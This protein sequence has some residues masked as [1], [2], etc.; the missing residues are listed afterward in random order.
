MFIADIVRALLAPKL[1]E[2]KAALDTGDYTNGAWLINQAC[3]EFPIF[4][5]TIR[6]LFNG[7]PQEALLRL[8]VYA[9][10]LEKLPN[11]VGVVGVLQAELRR[12]WEK[13]RFE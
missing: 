10:W 4:A 13:P 11:A 12:Q 7:T 3:D 1:E 5:G 2:L 9:P 8:K 6:D